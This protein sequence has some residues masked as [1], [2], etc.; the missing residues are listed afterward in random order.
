MN[1][2]KGVITCRDIMTMEE[3]DIVI[4]MSE[5]DVVHARLFTKF[6]NSTRRDSERC[7]DLRKTKLPDHVKVGYEIVQVRPFMH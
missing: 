6:E 3:V 7:I 1:S 2:C 5:Q 4:E